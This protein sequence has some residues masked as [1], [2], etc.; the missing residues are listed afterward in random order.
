MG[1]LAPGNEIDGLAVVEAPNTTLFV[2][3]GWHV[4]IDAYNVYW[5][6]R[7]EAA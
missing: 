6:T 3:A 5:L 1:A 7:R 4:R 2:P